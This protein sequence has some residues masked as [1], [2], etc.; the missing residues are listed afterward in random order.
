MSAKINEIEMNLSELGVLTGLNLMALKKKLENVPIARTG[1]KGSTLY[2][3]K[4]ALR[5]IYVHGD[6]SLPALRLQREKAETRLAEAK[7][8]KVELENAAS[9]KTLVPMVEAQKMFG[10]LVG[11][12]RTKIL[13]IPSKAAFV[14]ANMKNP[15]QIEKHLKEHICEALDALSQLSTEPTFESN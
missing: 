3:L 8:I 14:V 2:N 6:D 11:S 4:V 1:P 10:D 15:G 5:A 12:F 9:E 7:A 13:A